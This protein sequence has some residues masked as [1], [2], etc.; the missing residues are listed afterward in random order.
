MVCFSTQVR[1]CGSGTGAGPVAAGGSEVE[2]VGSPVGAAGAQDLD[3][4]ALLQAQEPVVH[5]GEGKAHRGDELGA[6]PGALHVE[7]LEEEI[8]DELF[9]EPGV[10]DG[11]GDRRLVGVGQPLAAPVGR[12]G[13]GE[14]HGLNLRPERWYHRPP[15]CWR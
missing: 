15:F 7:G 11:L 6:G 12:C 14:G 9:G 1:Y 3:Q 8:D 5:E 13:R 4:A 2:D 10:P